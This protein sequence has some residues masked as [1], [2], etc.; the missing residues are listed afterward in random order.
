MVICKE[1]G[2]IIF[3]IFANFRGETKSYKPCPTVRACNS[4]QKSKNFDPF[5]K[6][7]NPLLNYSGNL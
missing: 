2:D 3:L 6:K 1:K 7:R 5:L 4:G